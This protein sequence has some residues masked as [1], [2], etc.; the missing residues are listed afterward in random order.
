[1]E[2]RRAGERK[3]WKKEGGRGGGEEEYCCHISVLYLD[4]I[5]PATTRLYRESF[6][7]LESPS[8]PDGSRVVPETVVVFA[9]R[10]Q[11]ASSSTLSAH[12]LD[13][14]FDQLIIRVS[15]QFSDNILNYAMSS[16][17]RVTSLLTFI[18]CDTK[19]FISQERLLK[20]YIWIYINMNYFRGFVP[21]CSWS[22][23]CMCTWVEIKSQCL[24]GYLPWCLAHIFH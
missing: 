8:L 5:P 12:R 10:K 19:E 22:W 2:G 9:D 1:M 7:F 4:P 11:E 24:R 6:Q 18:N 16:F 3:K 21:V 14:Y 17:C 20:S 15:L 13:C 23:M